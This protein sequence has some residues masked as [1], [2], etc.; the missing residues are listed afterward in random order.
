MGARW[1]FSRGGQIRGM[2]TLGTK[3]SQRGPGI[4]LRWGFE[5]E[6]PEAKPATGCENNV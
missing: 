2:G 5:G 3:V 4:D 6:V 1:I